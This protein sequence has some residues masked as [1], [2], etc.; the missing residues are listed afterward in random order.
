MIP[1][2]RNGEVLDAGGHPL[3]AN[4][5]ATAVAG[6]L[7]LDHHQ[8]DG[9]V[10]RILYS[11][12]RGLQL[13]ALGLL[14]RAKIPLVPLEET[15]RQV[16]HARAVQLMGLGGDTQREPT[17]DVPGVESDDLVVLGV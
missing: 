1:I 17:R 8:S 4:S 16:A 15:G 10:C 3:H 2:S 11:Y 6:Q 12:A 9:A 5:V 7:Y 14:Q 13:L